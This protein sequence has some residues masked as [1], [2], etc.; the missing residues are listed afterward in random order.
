MPLIKVAKNDEQWSWSFSKH[1][2]TFTIGQLP[3]YATGT[4]IISIALKEYSEKLSKKQ[5]N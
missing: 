2:L 4:C 1:T 5:Y 3:I